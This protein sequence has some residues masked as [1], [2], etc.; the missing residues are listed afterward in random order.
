MKYYAIRSPFKKIVTSWFEC[1]KLVKGVSGTEFKSFHTM[2]EAQDF[3]H[4]ATSSKT[5][6]EDQQNVLDLPYIGTRVFVDGS[7]NAPAHLYGGSAI[8]IDDKP[9]P[10][11]IQTIQFNGSNPDF[12][13]S[14]NISGEIGATIRAINY[15]IKKNIKELTIIHDY[16]GIAKWANG[17][18]RTDKTP[19]AR[20]YNESIVNATQN[21]NL[22]LK[23]IWVKGHTG[24]KYNEQCDKLA[25]EA[26]GIGLK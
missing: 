6:K 16:E 12:L 18:W 15:A 17:L 26:C 8:F 11:V 24:V 2:E 22:K 20:A 23:F 25:K 1:E 13:R 14:R 4:G 10:S 21:H 7:F 5:S 19:I 9:E 3:I